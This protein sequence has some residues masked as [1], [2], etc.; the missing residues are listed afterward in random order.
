MKPQDD[1]KFVPGTQNNT[2]RNKEKTPID[3]DG[4]KIAAGAVAGAAIG[5]GAAYVASEY[6]GNDNVEAEAKAEE[7]AKAEENASKNDQN[8][9]TE[10]EDAKAHQTAHTGTHHHGSEEQLDRSIKIDTIETTTDA[11]GQVRHI[12]S[13]TVDGH[14]VAFVTMAMAECKL[15]LLTKTTTGKLTKARYTM[16]VARVLQ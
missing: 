5:G 15:P 14:Q 8:K 10:T 3:S 2:G 11:E 13:G 12:A 1:T 16:S 4:I 7:T 6:F 9:T